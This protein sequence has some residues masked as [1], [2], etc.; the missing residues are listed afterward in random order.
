MKNLAN[1]K[2]AIRSREYLVQAIY[3]LFFNEQDIEDIID[4]FKDEHKTK[5]VDFQ[6]FSSSLKSIQ[7]NRAQLKDILDDLGVNDP[8]MDL[9]D[10]AIFYFALNEMTFGVLDKPIVIDESIRLA[11]KFS[12][13]D[14]YKFINANLDKVINTK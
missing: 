13:P 7:A 10:K 3:Q 6:L 11:K 9:I 2:I 4:Q 14:S 1:H 5:K 12:S 8:D